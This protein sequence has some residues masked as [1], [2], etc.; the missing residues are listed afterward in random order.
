VTIA[1]VSSISANFTGTGPATSAAIN[2]T[3]ATLLVATVSQNTSGA[4]QVS[5]T[6]SYGNTWTS[7]TR[8]WSASNSGTCIYYAANPTVGAD[9]TFTISGES[10]TLA[11]FAAFSGVAAE[12]PF[13]VQNGAVITTSST[14]IQPGSITPSQAN[15][16]I[17]TSV[18]SWSN[19]TQAVNDGFTVIYAQ[20]PY[21]GGASAYLVQAGGPAAVNPT[22]SIPT[23]YEPMESA[24]AVFKP[25]AG[26]G[27][28]LNPGSGS[29]VFAGNTGAISLGTIL[30]PPGSIIDYSVMAPSVANATSLVLGPGS[31]AITGQAPAVAQAGAPAGIL[32][33]LSAIPPYAYSLRSLTRTYTGPLVTVQRASDG[34][35][36]SFSAVN[37]A[38]SASAIAAFCSGTTG[39]VTT[40]YNQGSAGSAG[41]LT[42]DAPAPG[43]PQITDSSGTVYLQNG[44]PALYWPGTTDNGLSSGTTFDI[45][46]GATSTNIVFSQASQT[47]GYDG[48][49]VLLGNTEYAN[50]GSVR[51]Y[52]SG[53]GLVMVSQSE[54]VFNFSVGGTVPLNT[55][56]IIT[57]SCPAV[58]SGEL[59]VA[60]WLNGTS[61]GTA[62]PTASAT[63]TAFCIG[64][65]PLNTGSEGYFYQGTM[66][67]AILWDSVISSADRTSLE[68][69][70]GAYYGVPG[71]GYIPGTAGVTVSGWAP[72]MTQ[73]LAPGVGSVAIDSYAPSIS[74]ALT[75]GTADLVVSGYAPAPMFPSILAP[76]SGVVAFSSYAPALSEKLLPSA[77]ALTIGGKTPTVRMGL[78]AGVGSISVTGYAPS[79]SF[80]QVYAPGAGAVS[81]TGK[82][83]DV[84]S[85]IAPGA[86]ALAFT[87]QAPKVAV[88]Y[89]PA[90]AD[91]GLTGYEPRVDYISNIYVGGNTLNINGLPPSV[92]YAYNIIPS[93]GQIVFLGGVPFVILSTL[94]AVLSLGTGSTGFAIPSTQTAYTI[95]TGASTEEP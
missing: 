30:S 85:G 19:E 33:Y 41:N 89:A 52:T 36:E 42:T 61:I 83:P 46:Y 32:D 44:L 17:V 11:Q 14:T 26:S 7:L 24:I 35:T 13:D 87:G 71:Y 75:P 59:A 29:V 50:S 57:T 64:E 22:W 8:Q 3:G 6:D 70:Q 21:Y 72:N 47:I 95:P 20:T 58:I 63:A 18:A 69:D 60:G 56:T 66:T 53:S 86:G 82:A 79:G 49:S 90:T 67:E 80:Q 31:Y 68:G 84:G 55:P 39:T 81:I 27:Q 34:T 94:P 25:A 10:S 12:G 43:Y 38:V 28:N 78:L 54:G 23:A 1:L 15:S 45:F 4:P 77:A 74:Q 40:W 51:M 92:Q 76:G 62:S 65:D 73:G 9:H 93:G 91:I 88:C 37:G 2:T 16:L 48:Y 5:V